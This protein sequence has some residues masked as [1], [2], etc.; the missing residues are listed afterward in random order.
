[1]DEPKENIYQETDNY[2]ASILEHLVGQRGVISVLRTHLNACWNDRLVGRNPSLSHMLYAGPSGTGKT[3]TAYVLARE[4]AVPIT[5]VTADALRTS[6]SCHQTLMGLETDSILFIDE[7]HAISR[8]PVSETIL[9]KAL[10]ENKVCLGNTRSEKPTIV[11][12]PRFTCICATTDPWSLHPAFI[13][14]FT[15]L[16]FD[17]YS[18]EELTEIVRRKARSMKIECE[19]GVLEALALKG[20]Q[21]PRI[22]LSLFAAAHKTARSENTDTITMA[23]LEKTMVQ[24]GIDELGLDVVEQKYLQLLADAGGIIRLHLLSMQLGLP[25]RTLTKIIEPF[26]VRQGL[27]ISSD[28][29]RELT[30]AGMEYIKSRKD[31]AK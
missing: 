23:H 4:L 31:V 22:C 9:L 3:Q 2:Q 16:N 30:P 25:A 29:G 21:T 18:V 1:M 10:A 11:E 19:A 24:R 5:V 6:Q 17:F 26:L 12:L 28:K 14:R 8:F 7:V 13:Q 15:V 27:I 20:K